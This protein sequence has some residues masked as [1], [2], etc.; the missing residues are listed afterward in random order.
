MTS[1]RET[2]GETHSVSNFQFATF[3]ACK[4]KRKPRLLVQTNHYIVPRHTHPIQIMI[5]AACIPQGTRMNCLTHVY[6][7]MYTRVASALCLR[8][9]DLVSLID[10]AERPCYVDILLHAHQHAAYLNHY[11]ITTE[12]ERAC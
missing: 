11:A 5:A 2:T 4:S 3:A 8:E 6:A 7:H 9:H 12:L 10:N 1:N